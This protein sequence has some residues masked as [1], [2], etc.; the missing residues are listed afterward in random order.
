MHGQSVLGPRLNDGTSGSLGELPH[1]LGYKLQTKCLLALFKTHK[2][3]QKRRWANFDLK[4][5]FSLK[6]D[7]AFLTVGLRSSRRVP[8][9]RTIFTRVSLITSGVFPPY[10]WHTGWMAGLANRTELPE[11]AES[12]P[13][14][15]TGGGTGRGEAWGLLICFL[16][17]PVKNLS[18]CS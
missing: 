4:N 15:F 18:N 1:F 14:A 12:L 5:I 6:I 8:Y 17:H 11:R 10:R 7:T 2:E 16:E 3:Q 9:P 13:S